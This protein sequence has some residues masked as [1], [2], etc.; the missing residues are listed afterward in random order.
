MDAA[1]M[2]PGAGFFFLAETRNV[3]D[4]ILSNPFRGLKELDLSLFR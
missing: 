3:Q 2:I 1:W 4:D